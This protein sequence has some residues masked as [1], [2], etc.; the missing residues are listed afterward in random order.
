MTVKITIKWKMLLLD[1]HEHIA[2]G[3]LELKDWSSS[4][5]GHHL[6]PHHRPIRELCK[7]IPDPVTP[8]SSPGCNK[9]SPETLCGFSGQEPAVS[10]HGPAVNLSL[11][12]SSTFQLVGL[13]YAL[14]TGT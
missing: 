11:L 3:L 6:L 2:P 7:L 5:L 8:P 13:H 4:P 14:G 9:G 1:G 10:L 12:Q